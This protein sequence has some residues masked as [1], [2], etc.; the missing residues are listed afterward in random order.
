[1]TSWW[2][3]GLLVGL[4]LI[5]FFADKIPAVNHVN[6]IIQTFVRPA[7]GAIA[8]AASA[9]IISNVH[10]VLAL[11]FGLMVAG[12]V[13]ATKSLAVRPA[14]TATTAGAGNVPVSIAED[15]VSTL[16]SILSVVVPVSVGCILVL[17]TVDC[18][19]AVPRAAA[20][21]GV[22]ARDILLFAL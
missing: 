1:L 18:L 19:A 10:P 9:N 21:G 14:G 15:V 20:A 12:G 17:V 3:I 7:A 13:H 11:A 8:F 5:E 4:S 6:D 16:L 22:K 2:I